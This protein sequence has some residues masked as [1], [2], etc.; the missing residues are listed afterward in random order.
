MSQWFLMLFNNVIANLNKKT[1]PPNFFKLF[2]KIN[3]AKI[4]ISDV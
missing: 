2:N 3:V 1:L 4:M